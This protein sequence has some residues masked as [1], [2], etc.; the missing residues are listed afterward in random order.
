MSGRLQNLGA[1][2]SRYLSITAVL[3]DQAN[4]V[5]SFNDQ[6]IHSPDNLGDGQTTDFKVCADPFGQEVAN[7]DL[8]AWGL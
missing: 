6:Y 7:H 1:E 3:Y 4:N 2:L 8:R 5:I